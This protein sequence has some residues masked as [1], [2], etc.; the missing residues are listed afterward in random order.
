MFAKHFGLTSDPFAA[1]TATAPFEGEQAAQLRR[2]L[3]DAM[4]DGAVALLT[5]QEGVGKTTLL[6]RLAEDLRLAGIPVVLA[7]CSGYFGAADLLRCLA[8]RKA[9]SDAA[10]LLDNAE[11]LGDEALRQFLGRLADEKP[12]SGTVAV[13]FAASADFAARFE[14]ALPRRLAPARVARHHLAPLHLHEV[15]G[16]IARRLEA[17]GYRGGSL[18]TVDAVARIAHES[19]G[20]PRRINAIGANGL[21]LAFLKSQPAAS[22]E[23]IVGAPGGRARP[24]RQRES[25]A[26]VGAVE[27][28]GSGG[29]VPQPGPV[30]H[31]TGGGE[32]KDGAG[33]DAAADAAPGVVA[34]LAALRAKA[35]SPAAASPVPAPDDA[36]TVPEPSAPQR[37]DTKPPPTAGESGLTAGSK[38]ASLVHRDDPPVAVP[39]SPSSA[40]PM[41]D[42]PN[43][44]AARTDLPQPPSKRVVE[45]VSAG[46]MERRRHNP[47]MRRRR[48]IAPRAESTSEPMP[49]PRLPP[50]L[51]A[52]RASLHAIRSSDIGRRSRLHPRVAIPLGLAA[53]AAGAFVLVGLQRIGSPERL[54]TDWLRATPSVTIAGPTPP[55]PGAPASPLKEPPSQTAQETSGDLLPMRIATAPPAPG[56]PEFR[57]PRKPASVAPAQLSEDVATGITTEPPRASP[58]ASQ[59][60]AAPIVAAGSR[61]SPVPAPAGQT[62][63]GLEDAPPIAFRSRGSPEGGEPPAGSPRDPYGSAGSP[64]GVAHLEMGVTPEDEPDPLLAV[65]PLPGVQASVP[66]P[67]APAAPSAPAVQERTG[68]STLS[69][70]PEV[71]IDAPA[72]QPWPE[73]AAGEVKVLATLP[74]AAIVVPSGKPQASAGLVPP[75]AGHGARIDCH[76]LSSEQLQRTAEE[77]QCVAAF[78]SYVMATSVSTE[79]ATGASILGSIAP[80][81]GPAVK[82]PAVQM[83]GLSR[84]EES[85]VRERIGNPAGSE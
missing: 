7:T 65:P 27:K 84:P 2:E 58:V 55:I 14:K 42:S 40:R 44:E 53:V 6:R 18:F 10:L 43:P 35:A 39:P 46:T 38:S 16:Y 82:P 36:T 73:P 11:Q 31:K 66:P 85:L 60:P 62:E 52:D 56:A 33:M 51:G 68:T 76:A 17:V 67:D 29:A 8:S 70:A 61:I 37:D 69:V 24:A 32:A 59:D 26:E 22:V 77:G 45:A 9:G 3:R 20:V 13:L 80:A 48:R 57:P 1:E 41:S 28:T 79:T 25:G 75:A 72:P 19:Q 83:R 63:A 34:M 71:E 47:F 64:T 49:V 23:H 4:Q 78:L 21:F 15:G 74:A 81:A 5:G 12:R 54:F 50:L 30:E